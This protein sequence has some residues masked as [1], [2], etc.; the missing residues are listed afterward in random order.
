MVSSG[1]VEVQRKSWREV[2]FSVQRDRPG[3]RVRFSAA[4]A[5][6][7]WHQTSLQVE[8]LVSRRLCDLDERVCRGQIEELIREEDVRQCVG[9][10]TQRRV[11]M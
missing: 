10:F 3:R 1:C 2:T 5:A 11:G 7:R 8:I 9:V 6:S 4:F